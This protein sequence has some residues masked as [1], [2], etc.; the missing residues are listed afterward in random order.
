MMALL[1]DD[2]Q[3]DLTLAKGHFAQ[4]VALHRTGLAD[5]VTSMA[6]QHAMQ[7]GYTGAGLA[8]RP[9]QTARSR[10]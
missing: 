2:I 10:R 1:W 8:R 5:Y 4:A 3:E 9:G 7:S 6:F